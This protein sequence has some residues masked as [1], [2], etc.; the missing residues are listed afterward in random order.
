MIRLIEEVSLN[1]WPAAQTLLYDGW[2]LRFASGYTRR[3]NSVQPLYPGRLDLDEKIR[4]CEEH[5]RRQHLPVI[6]KLTLESQP[7]GLDERLDA[8]GYQFDAL[9]SVQTL[10]LR[11]WE[12]ATQPTAELFEGEAPEWQAAFARLSG[13]PADKQAAHLQILRAI[14]PQTAYAVVRAAGGEIVACGLAVLEAGCI[15]LFDIVTDAASRRQGH[16]ERLVRDLLAWGKQRGASTAYLQVMCN[17]PP[18]LRLYEKIGYRELY[19]Y[20]YRVKV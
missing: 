8:L 18:A 16:G 17:N 6:F 5:Y 7:A 9:T 1:A 10:D 12:A 2:V 11:G 4:T 3:A 20:W 14:L 19:R 13:I 15:G